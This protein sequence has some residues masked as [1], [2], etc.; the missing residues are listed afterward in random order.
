MKKDFVKFK[1]SVF[2]MGK[3]GLTLAAVIANSGISVIGVDINP[4]IVKAIN[5]GKSTIAEEPGLDELIK[6]V[7]GKML[8]ATTDGVSAVKNS[9]VHIIIVPLY[10]DEKNQ[11]DYQNILLVARV[12]AQ[13]LKK[14][15]LVILETTAPVGTTDVIL[16]KELEK[17]SGLKVGEFQLAHS[18]E[19]IMTGY[20]ISRFKEFP[21]VVAGIDKQS[22]D[23]CEQ[24]YKQFCSKVYRVSSTRTAELTKIAEGMYRDVNIAIANELYAISEA[25]G[26]NFWEL[27]KAAN[28]EYCN[29][30]EAGIGVG[31]HCIPVYPHFLI[32]DQ[33]LAGLTKLTKTARDVNDAMAEYFAKKALEIV[34]ANKHNSKKG[35]LIIGLTYREGVK[36][37]AYTR[38]KALIELLK[39]S[40][41]IVKGLDPLLNKTEIKQLFD[42]ENAN[43][44]EDWS[45]YSC[46]IIVNKEKQYIQKLKAIDPKVII[47]CKNLL[48]RA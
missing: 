42:I 10:I 31:G 18:P 16:R 19:R 20:S 8:K 39:K 43:E 23:S 12:I 28:H 2:G 17:R 44:A 33:K 27:R 7:A 4:N 6:N 24:F 29:I 3:A 21:K 32:Q 40:K 1:A 34:N 37:I 5:E 35:I 45:Q 25:Y 11:P 14:G 26:V 46:I 9:N 41:I 13:G 48:E 15:D 30:L 47:D 38:A 36:E 22:G